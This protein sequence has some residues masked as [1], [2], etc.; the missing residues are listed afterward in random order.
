MPTKPERPRRG[1]SAST[2]PGPVRTCVVTREELPPDAL[3]R[4]CVGPDGRVEVDYRG[5]LPGRGAWVQ[6]RRA[7][8][9]QLAA[10]PGL[11]RKALDAPDADVDG[12]LERMRAAN[13]RAFLELLSLAARSGALA[14]GADQVAA[15]AASGSI[16]A[17]VLASDASARSV[18]AARAAA[19]EV[20]AFT[21]PVTKEALGLRVGKGPRAVIGL[22]SAAVTRTLLC[23]LR[24][25][26]DL[27]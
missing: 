11:L 26:E 8:I 18:E 7:L 4:L 10:R 27:R 5:R 21:V 25:M 23:E 22:R 15:S 2:A 17:F 9:D 1:R 14:S 6:P 24:R 12:I 19:P 20:P 3:V 13:V 16:I